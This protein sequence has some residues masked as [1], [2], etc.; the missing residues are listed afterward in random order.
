[1]KN[2]RILVNLLFCSGIFPA[3]AQY[4]TSL[5]SFEAYFNTVIFQNQSS[6]SNAH[7][8]WNFG[9]GTGSYIQNPTHV[10][11]EN[12]NYFVTLFAEDTVSKCSSYYEY[13]VNVTKYSLDTCSPFIS[14]SIYSSGGSEYLNIFNTIP[15]CNGYQLLYDGAGAVN[16]TPALMPILLSADFHSLRTVCRCRYFDN[17][18]NLKR[19]AYKTAYYDYTSSH[20]YGACSANFEFSAVSKAPSGERI[21]F[22]AMNKTAIYYDWQILG[23]GN[24]ISSNNDTISQFYPFASNNLWLVGLIT[25][26]SSGCH[27][28]IYQNILVS[29]SSN[30]IENVNEL[31]KKL[32]T[33]SI[34]PNPN[35]GKLTISLQDVSG[36]TRV[37]VFNILGEQVY[38]ASL[39]T[40]N[41]EIDLSDKADGIY[42]Y[43]VVTETG[44]L[45]SQGKFVKQ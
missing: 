15:N 42:M 9:D 38:K 29:D 26:D 33:V 18:W 22:R 4:C 37:T 45:V 44:S 27:D 7:Y 16:F 43:R 19:E 24:P 23:F 12:G 10:F 13:W 41:T 28:T 40:T 6:V 39:N 2:F 14:D 25:Q 36:K 35:N 5:F 1:M 20:N 30:T 21:L 3:G 8:F 31:A 11:P 34:Y 17:G 32:G